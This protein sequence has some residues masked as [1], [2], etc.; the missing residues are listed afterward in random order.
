MKARFGR[1]KD[2]WTN[3]EVIWNENNFTLDGTE[4]ERDEWN[5]RC[6]FLS[7]PSGFYTK[8]AREGGLVRHRIPAKR[9]VEL[10]KECE[11]KIDEYEAWIKKTFGGAA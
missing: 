1:K 6:Y 2:R 8:A 3:S 10:R 5:G 9:F 11:T 7:T 4:Y